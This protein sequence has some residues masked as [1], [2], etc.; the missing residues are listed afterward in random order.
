MVTTENGNGSGGRLTLE[1]SS[2]LQ[3]FEPSMM[4]RKLYHGGVHLG[5]YFLFSLPILFLL[6]YLLPLMYP[7]YIK[8]AANLI[9]SKNAF[10]FASEQ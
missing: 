7:P 4:R 5:Y 2:T 10:R 8:L 6:L 9:E 3:G 1:W